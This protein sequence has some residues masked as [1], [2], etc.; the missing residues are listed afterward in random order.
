MCKSDKIMLWMGGYT[1]AMYRCPN[2]GYV[3][4]L[5]IE[6]TDDIPEEIQKDD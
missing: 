4:P 1:G 6:T 2:C 5:V 3:G